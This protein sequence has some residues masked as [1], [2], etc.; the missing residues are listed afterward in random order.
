M[1]GADLDGVYS[2]IDFLKEAREKGEGFDPGKT[3]VVVG[4]GDVAVDC[5]VT[6]KLLGAT[7]VRIL[8]RRSIEEAPAEMAEFEYALN[9]GIGITTGFYPVAAKG[10]GKLEEI[11]AAG[12]KDKAA[13]MKLSADTLVFATGQKAEDQSRVAAVKLTDKGTIAADDNGI[14]GDGI[15]AAGDIVN[16]GQT[17]VEAVAEAKK[18]AAAIVDYLEEKGVK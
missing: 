1:E 8:Y 2:A 17:V 7:D 18:A 9:L 5:A 14:A 6:A 16:G 4:G 10:N 11:E 13:G 15:F 12:F 3:V